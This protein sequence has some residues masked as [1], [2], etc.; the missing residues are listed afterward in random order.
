MTMGIRPALDMHAVGAFVHSWR[1]MMFSLLMSSWGSTQQGS[2]PDTG[3]EP[4][5]H[6][7]CGY[8]LCTAIP[9]HLA[10]LYPLGGEQSAEKM[11]E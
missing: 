4:A 10:L 1:A 3:E 7:C 2:Y 11:Y 8:S 6:K 9:L 5:L